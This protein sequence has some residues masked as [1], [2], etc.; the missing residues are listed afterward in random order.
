MELNLDYYEKDILYNKSINEEVENKIL[1]AIKEAERTNYDFID[2]GSNCLEIN[3]ITSFR[4]NILEWYDFKET[5]DVLEI[6][7]EYGIITEFL[8]EKFNNVISID[9]CKSR[10]TVIADKLK[11]KENLSVIVGNLKN[12]KINKKFDYIVMI[13]MLEN[14]K[15]IFGDNI[16]EFLSYLKSLLKDNGTILLVTD[17]KLGVRY[18]SGAIN[19]YTSKTLNDYQEKKDI[20]SFSKAELIGILNRNNLKN[21]NFYYPLPDYKMTN[22]IFSDNYLPTFNNSKLMYNLNYIEGSNIVLNELSLLK[23][24]TKNNNFSDVANCYFVEIFKDNN[25]S[26]EDSVRFVSYNNLRKKEYRLITKMYNKV[27]TKTVHTNN[28]KHHFNSLKKNIDTLNKLNFLTLD[29][30][31]GDKIISQYSNL[32]AFNRI[33]SECIE[34]NDKVKLYELLEL[35][36]NKVLK[37]LDIID[38]NSYIVEK[39]I[40]KKF[41]INIEE[42]DLNNL[43][44][45]KDGLFDLVF[46]NAFIDEKENFIFYDQEWYEENVPIEFILYRAIN[47][48]YMYS[49]DINEIIPK[50]EIFK[51]FNIYEYISLFDKLEKCIQNKILDSNMIKYSSKSYDFKVNIKEQKETIISLNN[52]KNILNNRIKELENYT[53]ELTNI[54]KQL[55]EENKTFNLTLNNIYNSRGWKLLEKA[56]KITGKK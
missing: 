31:N 25:Y 32:K 50:I 17:N 53:D 42:N 2:I 11:N 16:D 5:N 27:V 49:F 44:F 4:K 35:W 55:S 12:I 39:N 24:F 56:R 3:N 43:H 7:M 18:L 47:N 45:T 48:L 29:S 21:Y 40:F 51:H 46:E 9:F 30:F 22:V 41:N 14:Y 8:C 36:N 6:G 19:E 15:L 13:G 54:I 33:L 1:N 20:E 38:N 23:E 28:S 34:V 26:N 37:K 10:A 52:D